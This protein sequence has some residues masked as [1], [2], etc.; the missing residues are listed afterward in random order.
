M[1]EQKIKPGTAAVQTSPQ[2]AGPATAPD[3]VRKIDTRLL[4]AVEV[5]LEGFL[6]NARITVGDLTALKQGSV[7]ALDAA[8]NSAVEL[9]LNGSAVARGEL[10]AVGDKF[11]VRLTE[12][13]S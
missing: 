13:A 12:I 4:E 10:V 5:S 3:A 2:S 8:L 1:T 6:G 7:V 9:R 11:A